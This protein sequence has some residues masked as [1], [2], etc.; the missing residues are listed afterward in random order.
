M[1][2]N[3]GPTCIKGAT[4]WFAPWAPY[5]RLDSISGLNLLKTPPHA[6]VGVGQS[7]ARIRIDVAARTAAV[8]P[9]TA[10]AITAG[11]NAYRK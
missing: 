10:A 1:A 9:A 6:E 11:T 7:A 3:E 2:L 8:A 4:L 5:P